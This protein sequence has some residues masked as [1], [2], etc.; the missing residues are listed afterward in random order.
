MFKLSKS[1][2]MLVWQVGGS[3]KIVV[4]RMKIVDCMVERM[5][6]LNIQ[7]WD[8]RYI[9]IYYVELYICS[10]LVESIL[11]CMLQ[12]E[13][14]VLWVIFNVVGR[15]KLVDFV[16]E[17]LSNSVFGLFGV[18]C[19]GMKVVIF[20]ECYQVVF[21]V[22]KI[23]DEGVVVVV[24]FFC[25]LGLRMEEV[26]QLVKLLCIWQQVLLCGDECV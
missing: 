18:S 21:F 24:Q 14:V 26:V 20:D 10:C 5:L 12:N 17:C 25:C 8:V 6:N 11:K 19:D 15:L 1:L 22:I 16:Y 9:K 13:M 2:L 4:D 3:F 7:I 23:K